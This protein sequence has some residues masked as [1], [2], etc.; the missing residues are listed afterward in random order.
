MHKLHGYM[1]GITGPCTITKR[2]EAAALMKSAC[3]RPTYL[4]NTICLSGEEG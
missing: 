2:K 4:S 1:L 3:H